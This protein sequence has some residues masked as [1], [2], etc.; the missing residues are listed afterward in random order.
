[1][2]THHARRR[3]RE[4]SPE[5]PA[6]GSQ[7]VRSSFMK[8]LAPHRV[9]MLEP[10][11]GAIQPSAHRSHVDTFANRP[12]SHWVHCDARSELTDPSPQAIHP[13]A[14]ATGLYVPAAH[15]VHTSFA[16]LGAVPASQIPQKEPA[17]A[18]CPDAQATH[19]V[20]ASLGSVPAPQAAHADAL[21]VG[22]PFTVPSGHGSHATPDAD[23]CV[24]AAH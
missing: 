16:A 10:A 4:A 2:P 12:A 1:M 17:A 3:R 18:A 5:L 20:A 19:A 6:H 14:P 7:D 9:Q 11:K 21:D 24:P 15:G 8:K 13:G 22:A 23:T